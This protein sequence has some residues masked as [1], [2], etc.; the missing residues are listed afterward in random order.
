MLEQEVDG[1]TMCSR[2]A[3]K[4]L[5]VLTSLS[6]SDSFEDGYIPQGNAID[7]IEKGIETNSLIALPNS[8][9][10]VLN[11]VKHITLSGS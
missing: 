2:T 11:G 3:R 8:F 9:E 1:I 6:V 4:H 5:G 10:T 7:L